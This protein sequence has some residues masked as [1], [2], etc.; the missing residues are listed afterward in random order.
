MKLRTMETQAKV[1]AEPMIAT[2][3]DVSAFNSNQMIS[4]PG[5][6][7]PHPRYPAHTF[8]NEHIRSKKE[9][10]NEIEAEET[11]E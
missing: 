8:N 6:H 7:P 1:T 2:P 10:H 11:N 5:C 9:S 4:G 3:H